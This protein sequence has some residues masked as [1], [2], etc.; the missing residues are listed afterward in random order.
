MNN[1]FY[2]LIRYDGTIVPINPRGA[3]ISDPQVSRQHARILFATDR[4]WIWDENSALG[5]YVNGVRV[6][7]KQT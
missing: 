1:P 7:P 6:P 2:H 3:V 5:T 4:C